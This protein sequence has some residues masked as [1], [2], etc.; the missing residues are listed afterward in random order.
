MSWSNPALGSLYAK[1]QGVPQNYDQAVVWYRK[2]AAQGEPS[3]EFNLGARYERGKGGVV[4]NYTKG[5]A[6]VLVPKHC[7][8]GACFLPSTI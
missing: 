7:R 1:G 2:S 8:P 5:K 4:Q 6:S 3:G